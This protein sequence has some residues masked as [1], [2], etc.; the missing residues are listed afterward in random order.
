MIS[1]FHSQHKNN[2]RFLSFMS[3]TKG[4]GGDFYKKLLEEY[5]LQYLLKANYL[6]S[7]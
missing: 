1:D 6:L 5:A 7:F 4:V 3:A 2:P